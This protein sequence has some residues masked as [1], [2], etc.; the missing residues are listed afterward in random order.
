MRGRLLLYDRS[1]CLEEYLVQKGY[2]LTKNRRKILEVFLQSD[3]HWITA[4]ELFERVLAKNRR[5]NFSTVYRNL[6][7]LT[8]IGVLC[9]VD[10][11]S[12]THYYTLNN[13]DDHHHHLICKSCGKTCKI[14]FCPLKAMGIEHF[15]DFTVIEHK[16]EIYGYC[17]ECKRLNKK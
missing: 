14:D 8:K 7:M 17:K 1:S 11:G 10:K 13:Q 16:F 2:K 15:Q 4:Q 3:A 9:K 6:E 5:I 12:G